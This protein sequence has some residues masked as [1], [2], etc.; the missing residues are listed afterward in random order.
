MAGTPVVVPH[1]GFETPTGNPLVVARKGYG[2]IP[3]TAREGAMTGTTLLKW[4]LLIA[5]LLLCLF[6]T[7][8][9]LAS[10]F[11]APSWVLP[12]GCVCGFASLTLHYLGS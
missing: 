11:S 10:G 7:L 4:L 1:T 12:I 2:L 6:A 3:L 8:A 5:A 9:A